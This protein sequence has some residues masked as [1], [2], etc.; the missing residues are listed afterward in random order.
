MRRQGLSNDGVA[1]VL[2]L[3][4]SILVSVLH[5]G[6][7]ATP[8]FFPAGSLSP[9][10]T[11]TPSPTFTLR[12]PTANVTSTPTSTPTFTPTHTATLSP[13]PT[14]T[15]TPAAAPAAPGDMNFAFVQEFDPLS[16]VLLEAV[17][18]IPQLRNL[19]CEAAAIRMVLAAWDVR[20]SEEEILARMGTDENPHVG[21]RGDV[22]GY[23]HSD[24][25]SDYGTYAE[26][27]ERVLESFGVASETVYGMTDE[28]LRQ[29]VRDG[30]AV[31]VW[32]TAE[33][34]PIVLDVDGGGER[35]RLVEGEH[36]YVV[37]GISAD[38]RF[39]IHDPWG[40][41][42]GSRWAGTRF[43]RRIVQWDLFDRMAVVVP[44]P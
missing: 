19:S 10:F 21:F 40:A 12:A 17:P 5:P 15:T 6:M 30:S 35:F 28:H 2:P 18:Q 36:T 4:L 39:L 22:D 23:G 24:D 41:R 20:A 16:E 38:G 8:A 14:L 32:T 44:L 27:V 3:A 33:S 31:I 43:V 1:L 13:V 37:V 34:N 25:L 42:P 11:A 7:S 29:A 9:T 26:V